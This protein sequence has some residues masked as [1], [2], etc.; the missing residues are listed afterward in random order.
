MDFLNKFNLNSDP[1]SAKNK[2]T[3]FKVILAFGLIIITYSIMEIMDSNDKPKNVHE[4]VKVNRNI[5]NENEMT[6]SIWLGEASSDVAFINKQFKD[7]S[8]KNKEIEKNYKETNKKIKQILNFL[9]KQEETREE[10]K[11]IEKKENKNIK[12]VDGQIK[13]FPVPP[14]TN[15]NQNHTDNNSNINHD[16]N[17]FMAP[18]RKETKR[19]MPMSDVLNVFDSTSEGDGDKKKDDNKN[20][21]KLEILP[22]GSITKIKLLS[23]FDAPTMAQAKTNPLPILMKVDDISKLPNA[24]KYDIKDCHVIGEGY[25]DLS[26]ERAYIRTNT[27]S[28]VTNTGKH[29]DMEFKGM[30][31]GEDGKIGLRG[32]VV[33]KQGAML[34]RT[35]IAGFVGSVGE[36]FEQQGQSVT[37]SILGTTTT[38]AIDGAEALRSGV[39]G[40]IG[41]GAEKLADFYL[42]MADQTAPVIE[43]SAGRT[44]DLIN[45]API[46]FKILENS[47]KEEK[48]VD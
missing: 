34:A 25:G 44:V 35:V 42:K 29:I 6:K 11:N 21:K 26:S 14:T 43:I 17:G 45:T 18:V 2:Q 7:I 28:C 27:I 10:P 39:Y 32:N 47:K 40:G 30:I 19:I 16:K 5:V 23:G 9:K 48:R 37:D 12:V 36:A 41:K 13:F 22:S 31:S 1:S 15:L 20:I 3:L 33:T 24:A 4:K 8:E 38:S 46:E